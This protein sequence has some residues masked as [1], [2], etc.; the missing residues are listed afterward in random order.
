MKIKDK[1]DAGVSFAKELSALLD[2]YCGELSPFEAVGIMELMKMQLQKG[3]IE[4]LEEIDF[5]L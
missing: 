5:P 2:K 3:L 4:Q 1:E